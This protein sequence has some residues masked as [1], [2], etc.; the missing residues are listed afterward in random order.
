MV[1]LA[2]LGAS[3]LC[4]L[5]YVSLINS[6]TSWASPAGAVLLLGPLALVSYPRCRCITFFE[7]M[8]LDGCPLALKLLTRDTLYWYWTMPLPAPRL[9]RGAASLVA[10][11]VAKRFQAMEVDTL[12]DLG[13]GGAGPS[14]VIRRHLARVTGRPIRLHLTDLVPN[15]PAWSRF[16]AA[17][18]EVTFED[19][20]VDGTRVPRHLRG[21]RTMFG[22][23]HHLPPPVAVALLQDAVDCGQP[24]C[25]VDLEPSLSMLLMYSLVSSTIANLYALLRQP[26]WQRLFCFG[27][28]GF[29]LAFDGTVSV[30]R[31]YSEAELWS[32]ICKVKGHERFHWNVDRL[33]ETGMICTFGYQRRAVS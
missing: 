2:G 17:E 3:V 9:H 11:T 33:A 14:T 24:V 32:M 13:A 31:A 21:L 20:P 26:T 25:I 28:I 7:I 10:E 22:A 19:G 1:T 5:I 16:A 12:I 6:L 30:L 29:S 8:D 18:S 15:K 27:A 23:F 4:F